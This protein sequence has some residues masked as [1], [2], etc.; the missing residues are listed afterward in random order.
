MKIIFCKNF[1]KME[2]SYNFQL[3]LQGEKIHNSANA[4]QV[5]ENIIAMTEILQEV[6]NIMLNENEKQNFSIEIK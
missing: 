4:I 3:S 1:Q 6:A 5:G 2:N